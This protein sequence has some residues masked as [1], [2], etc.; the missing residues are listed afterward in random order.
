M[1]KLIVLSI[2]FIL[3]FKVVLADT[4]SKY[5]GKNKDSLDEYFICKAFKGDD[6]LEIGFKDIDDHKFVFLLSDKKVTDFVVNTKIFSSS[7]DERN[8]TTYMFPFPTPN[9]LTNASFTKNLN[10]QN[11]FLIWLDFIDT[12]DEWYNKYYE[13][14]DK[15][16][17]LKDFDN[18][19]IKYTNDALEI[20]FK[21]LDY[22]TPFEPDDLLS[23]P[24][25]DLGGYI[26]ECK[27]D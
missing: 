16:S 3:I 21:I 6:I 10:L 19:L 1:K 7:I 15:S 24:E 13:L 4:T 22:G 18:N 17:S 2:S 20:A 11:E 12:S 8:V 9:G 23:E 26:F 27:Q 14:L 5:Y 25:N